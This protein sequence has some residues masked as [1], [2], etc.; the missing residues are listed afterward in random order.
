[1]YLFI[2]SF[3][4]LFIYLRADSRPQWPITNTAKVKIE[5]NKRRQQQSQ[6]KKQSTTINLIESKVIDRNKTT[7]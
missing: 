5:N 6:D 4:Y 7:W 1:M 3:I 2:Y